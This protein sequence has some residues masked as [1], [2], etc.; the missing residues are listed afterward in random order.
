MMLNIKIC[1]ETCIEFN[2]SNFQF[3]KSMKWGG[4]HKWCHQKVPTP[5]R[6]Y[7][8][9]TNTSFRD[10]PKI[11][12]ISHLKRCHI[13][14]GRSQNSILEFMHPINFSK[15]K[16]GKVISFNKREKPTFP[17]VHLMEFKFQIGKEKLEFRMRSKSISS[18]LLEIAF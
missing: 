4:V 5:F 18:F 1:G 8:Y 14:Y 11:L 10:C 17:P 15:G 16:E 2:S 3:V 7:H 12:Q 6:H 13:I 9:I